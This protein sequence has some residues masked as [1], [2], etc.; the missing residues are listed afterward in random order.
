VSS[1]TAL[2]ALIDQA[3]ETFHPLAGEVARAWGRLQSKALALMEEKVRDPETREA[4][5]RE[6]SMFTS[7]VAWNGDMLNGHTT[8]QVPLNSVMPRNRAAA[9]AIADSLWEKG[10]I[11]D[12]RGFA[13]AAETPDA[14]WLA[15]VDPDWKCAVEENHLMWAGRVCPPE[16]VDDHEVHMLAITTFM[17]SRRFRDL[18]CQLTFDAER[19]P[20]CAT[21]PEPM[22]GEPCKAVFYMHL[23]AHQTMA[24]QHAGEL[25]ARHNTH[26]VAAATPDGLPVPDAVRATLGQSPDMQPEDL[27]SGVQLAAQPTPG[28][29]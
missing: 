22:M 12:A 6:N 28:A 19:M 24:M 20:S 29:L 1:G 16:E 10:L 5:I 7:K 8:A 15:V 26:P 17:K 3:D 9:M 2:A 4:T 27:A 25:V 13:A 18:P 23:K 21:H 14:D 11:K